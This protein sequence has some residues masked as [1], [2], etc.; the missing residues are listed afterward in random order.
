[1]TRF[2]PAPLA[3][4]CV[5]VLGGCATGGHQTIGSLEKVE[6]KIEETNLEGS[7][8]HA[9]AGYQKYLQET[10]ESAMTPEAIRRIADLKIKQAHQVEAATQANRR[11]EAPE[12]AAAQPLVRQLSSKPEN[13]AGRPALADRG[14]ESDRDFERRASAAREVQAS[15]ATPEL[16][17]GDA[18]AV[19]AA[20][21]AEAISLY[22]KLLKKYP[23]Y[24]RNDQVMY[25][26]SRAYEETGE[27]DKAVRILHRLVAE[28]PGSRHVDESYFRL[29]EYYFTRKKYLDAEEAYG[30][31]AAMGQASSFF[32]LA[33]Y[34]RGWAFF[35]QELYEEALDDF[36]AMLDYKR[37]RGYDFNQQ[38]N[39]VERKHVD[40]TFRVVSLSFSYLGGAESIVEYFDRKGERPYE[41]L[42]YSHLGEYYL[43]KRRY[44]DAAA[45][46]TAFVSRR[47]L[48]KVAPDF[49]IRV[50]E[51]YEKGGFPKLV[52]SSKKEFANTYALDANYWTVFD[53]NDYGHAYEFL[54]SNLTD[55][56]AHYH[57]AYQNKRLK[58]KRAENY[59]EAI[60]WYRRYLTSFKQMARAPQVN[61]QLAGLMLENRDFN[62]AGVEYERTAYD[63]PLHEQAGEAGYAAV[64]SY[65]EHL[66][67]NLKSAGA[68]ERAAFL[69]EIVRSSLRFAST[70]P[71][72][73][74]AARVQLGAVEDL[75]GLK[76]YAPAIQYGRALLEQFPKANTEIQHAAWVVIAHASFDTALYLEAE[77][78]YRVVLAMSVKGKKGQDQALFE[79][80]AASIYQQGVLA[81]D[82]G[83]HAQAAQ[84]FLRIRNAAPTASIL[85]TA[86]YD[87]AT[88]LINLAAWDRAAEVLTAFRANFPKH[89]LL[90]EVTK[91]LAVVYS[92]S[93]QLALAAQEFERIERE[94]DDDATRREAL[95]QAS[96]LYVA[97]EE[98][99]QAI[100][101]L[102]RYLKFFPAP[103]EPAIEVRQKVADIYSASGDQARYTQ[104]LE[105]LVR[106]ERSGKA[107]RTERTRYLGGH[108]ALQLAEP[109]F[110][111]FVA[112]PLVSPVER[113]INRKRSLMKTATNAFTRLIDYQVAEV[114]AAATFY[115]AEIYLE[116][117]V[118]LKDSERPTNLTPLEL[119]EYELALEEQIF[120][121]EERAISVHEKNIMLLG[122]GMYNHWVER[123]IGALAVLMP[124]R[125][126]RAEEYGQPL[127]SIIP[128]P[129]VST[130]SGDASADV[131]LE[132][133]S[134]KTSD[135]VAGEAVALEG[136]QS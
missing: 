106:I 18:D 90:G 74:N 134:N 133:A 119:E 85:A 124:A 116:F 104:A 49:A 20:N 61:F 51:I 91:K 100:N 16:P 126:A 46:Y 78:A 41:S 107:N 15:E 8:E 43:D 65:R 17:E 34:K 120:P 29:G 30:R 71:E 108:A 42:V 121:F 113:S 101:V 28:F 117:S 13:V 19:L 1:M 48:D 54:Q 35:K 129:Q 67:N 96:D 98:S 32:E 37:A 36:I 132:T 25:Q 102:N 53:I 11:P 97:A 136:G 80:L 26:L 99:S 127:P 38:T 40:D 60:H 79:N 112:V 131:S 70:Y 12:P 44:Q 109:A 122:R 76:E 69:R 58:D 59:Q 27:M 7:L 95:L 23:L 84:H 81:R 45:A 89:E 135:D 94:S 55:L 24:P 63:Y 33:L 14:L 93:G 4:A 125:Y 83:D 68:I 5:A 56:A 130:A 31:V 115:L 72:H 6:I 62:S 87:A 2:K 92:E 57:A 22:Q 105:R 82:T 3:L 114:T 128:L 9:L 88:A 103:F 52:L 73:E 39:K 111:A 123:S 77:K 50:I 21:A 64:F 118:A 86:E 110:E 47:P 10:P 66:A 75:Y